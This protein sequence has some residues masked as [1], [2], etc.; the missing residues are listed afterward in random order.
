MSFDLGP[1]KRPMIQES[2]NM[3]NNGGGGNLGY[4]AQGDGEESEEELY[5]EENLHLLEQS[6]DVDVVDIEIQ[7]NAEDFDDD[8]NI[9]LNPKGLLNKITN[10]LFNKH[11]QD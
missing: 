10:K 8:I 3:Q 1:I 11:K 6:D 5:E 4:M 7:D 9:N 2:Q